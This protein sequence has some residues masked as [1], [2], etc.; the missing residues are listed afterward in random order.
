[1][2]FLKRADRIGDSPAFPLAHSRYGGEMKRI[3][4]LALLPL[5]LSVL[6]GCGG[7]DSGDGPDSVSPGE[8][9]ALDDAAEM[10]EAQ[11]L[12][13]DALGEYPQAEPTEEQP[14]P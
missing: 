14:T 1:M 12:P 6:V 9:Q 2:M 7:P 11:R 4:T 3:V 10:I 13:P 5:S 8:A